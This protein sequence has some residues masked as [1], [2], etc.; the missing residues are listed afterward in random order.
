MSEAIL[1]VIFLS[2]F[3]IGVTLDLFVFQR[4]AHVVP[5]KEAMKLVGFWAALAASFGVLLFF[6]LGQEKTV[7]FATG[8]LIEYSLSVDNLFV[9][10]A[11]FT[12]FAVPREA[13][14]K[15]LTW[16]IL[17]AIFFRAIF[18]FAGI[19]LINRFHFLIYVL[20]AFLVYTSIKLATQKEK[21]V[22]PDKNPIVRL[23]RKIVKVQPAYDGAVF[24]TKKD[25]IKYWTPLII[26]LVAIEAMDIMF[27]V[28]SVPAVL[29]VTT[30]ALIVY[31]S[32]IFAILGLRSLY[33]ALAGLFH[34]FRYLSKGVC[35]VLGFVGVKMLLGLPY[36][37][38]VEVF[39]TGLNL[40]DIK[41]PVLVSLGVIVVILVGSI[42]FSLALPRKEETKEP[43]SG[44][45]SKK[46]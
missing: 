22:E 44:N 28:D 25:G 40:P 6:T 43:V 31:S 13:Q 16:G 7:L 1:W 14:R 5:I 38:L 17:G 34:L 19:G 20:G 45:S 27:A 15:I 11:L 23:V 29:A 39:K 35:L 46:E 12:Y 30:D 10:L 37:L 9:F 26:V 8:Y 2:I 41:I 4:K 32:N 24:R 3:V 18:I 36:Y 42:I 21:E 33:F